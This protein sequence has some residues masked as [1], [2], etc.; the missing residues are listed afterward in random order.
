MKNG[1][2]NIFLLVCPLKS[3]GQQ[4]VRANKKA[5]GDMRSFQERERARGEERTPL[6]LCYA[7]LRAENGYYPLVKK[8]I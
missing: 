5:C 3:K 1:T 8:I 4:E 2:I 7:A 6:R